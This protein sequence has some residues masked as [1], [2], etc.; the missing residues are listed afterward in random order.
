MSR[1]TLI[2]L[3]LKTIPLLNEDEESFYDISGQSSGW[4]TGDI[5]KFWIENQF[6][7]QISK[8]REKYDQ[9]CPVLV[10]LD[11]QSSRGSINFTKMRDEHGIHFLFILSHTSHVIQ[12]LDKMS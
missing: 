4:I 10:I 12:P 2:I 9:M 7:A 1:S 3:P 11:N 8:R 6:L 5:L